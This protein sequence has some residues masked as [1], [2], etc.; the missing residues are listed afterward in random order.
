MSLT[1]A[2]VTISVTDDGDGAAPR[3]PGAGLGIAGMR[4][5]ALMHGGE[6]RAGA[7]TGG[8][9]EVVAVLPALPPQ[10]LPPQAGAAGP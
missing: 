2:A 7:R 8:G 10:D 9:F 5:R 6:L 4:E 1:A 3:P